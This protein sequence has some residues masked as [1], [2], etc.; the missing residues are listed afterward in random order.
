MSRR[1]DRERFL[2]Q[3]KLNPDYPGFR[4]YSQEPDR[5]NVPLQTV[6]CSRCG[7]NRNIPVGTALDAGEQYICLSCQEEE[8]LST[9][10]GAERVP[11]PGPTDG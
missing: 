5:G 9:P 3:K 11:S 8:A 6:V 10:G 4:S 7:H 1:K 2:A